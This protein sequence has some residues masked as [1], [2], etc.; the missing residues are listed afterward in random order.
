MKLLPEHSR[1][2]TI[3]GISL[4]SADLAV[5]HSQIDVTTEK[6]P[7]PDWT[8]T[9]AAGHFHA[10]S[11]DGGKATLPTL[12]PKLIDVP[13]TGECGSDGPCEGYTITEY[14]CKICGEK[15]EPQ[16][17]YTSGQKYIPGRKSWRVSVTGRYEDLEPK[18]RALVSVAIYEDRDGGV[19]QFGV[20][21][22]RITEM[23][24][25]GMLSGIVDGAGELGTRQRET[26]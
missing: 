24:P 9:D 20:G 6:E 2:V 15:T 22:F 19:T 17:R 18:D 5:E 26:A 13:C 3:D 8:H 25:T 23:T 7:D 11:L 1:N 4:H 21:Y 14:R 10:Y 12:D 16:W